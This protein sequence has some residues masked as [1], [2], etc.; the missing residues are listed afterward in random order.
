MKLFFDHADAETGVGFNAWLAQLQSYLASWR[1]TGDAAGNRVAVACANRAMVRR[2][3]SL[4]Y[5]QGCF[6]CDYT[7]DTDDNVKLAEL[8][9]PETHWVEI[10]LVAFTQTLSVGV[11]PK[12]IKFA[13]VFLYAAG[14]GCTVSALAQGGLRFGRD[15]RFALRCKTVFVCMK[16]RPSE[17][18]D[19]DAESTTDFYQA[20]L[21]W[22][23]Q[24]RAERTVSEQSLHTAVGVVARADAHSSAAILHAYGGVKNTSV[25]PCWGW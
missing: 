7:R 24:E 16:G 23:M 6:W 11:D 2:V 21:N 12:E 15:E 1:R 5:E 25:G 13:A 9:D 22:L 18:G 17:I 10:A 19:Q 4:A 3:C 8:A 20:A 14:F